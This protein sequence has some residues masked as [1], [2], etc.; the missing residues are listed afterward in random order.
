MNNTRL[1]IKKNAIACLVSLSVL[2]VANALVLDFETASGYTATG[3]TGGVQGMLVGQGATTKWSSNKT[4]T[5][6]GSIKVKAAGGVSGSQSIQTQASN[7]VNFVQYRF[8]PTG[9]ELGGVFNA[10]STVINYSFSLKLDGEANANS[11]LSILRLQTGTGGNDM[12]LELTANGRL[13]ITNG[14]TNVTAK[15]ESGDTFVAPANTFFTV[16]G[17]IDYATKTYTISVNGVTQLTG[18]ASP[19]FSFSTSSNPTSADLFLLNMNPNSVD[20]MPV[21]IDNINYTAAAIP[22]P[23]TTAL[24]GAAAA[25]LVAASIRPRR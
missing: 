1:Y 21:T 20:W 3:G 17:T 25:G 23:S 19:N 22:E 14:S 5:D 15:T 11:T 2:P 16:A 24:L 18:S 4:D 8:V 12:K 10:S 6:D 13:G 9:A 7:S